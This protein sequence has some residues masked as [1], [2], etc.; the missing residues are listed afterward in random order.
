M[1]KLIFLY[2][3]LIACLPAKAQVQTPLSSTSKI[4]LMTVGQWNE[5]VYALFGHTA[6]RVKDDSTGIDM[7]FNYGYFDPSK[8]NFMLNFVR[9]RTDYVLGVAYYPEFIADYDR[10]GMEVVEQE[11]NLTDTEKQEL[12]NSLYINSL[13]ENRGYRY[14]YFFDNCATRPRDMIEKA[15]HGKIAYPSDTKQQ[16]L[17]DLVHECLQNFQWNRFGTDLVLGAG[18]DSTVVLR[19]KMFLPV[20]LMNA[21]EKAQI[22]KN[23]T[24]TIPLVAKKNQI[25]EHNPQINDLSYHSTPF[26]P[27][28]ISILLLIVSVALSLVQIAGKVRPVL[29]KIYDTLLFGVAGIAGC[30]IFF[31]MFF[32]I[33]PTVSHNWNFVWANVF[34]LMVPFL[35]W[36]KSAKKVIY[37]YHFIN[38]AVLMVFLLCWKWIPQSLPWESIPLSASLWIRSGANIWM[39]RKTKNN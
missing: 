35:V 32:S 33:H 30:I 5:E 29:P 20:Y 18:A 17:R 22:H 39:Q 12:Y 1:K 23:D 7:V 2:I 38:F 3:I 27:L 34:A 19:Q 11:L 10:R 31:L 26:S 14:N 6:I 15:I 28:N 13:P 36:A 21:F 9:G 8:P 4:S 16:S 25:L 24:I 37:W